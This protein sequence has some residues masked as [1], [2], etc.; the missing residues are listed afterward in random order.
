MRLR[1]AEE[2]YRVGVESLLKGLA[3]RFPQSS[4]LVVTGSR[5]D[6]HILFGV[7]PTWSVTIEH[8]VLYVFTVCIDQF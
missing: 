7:E 2:L 8:V 3:H 5:L 6:G 1:P 4:N